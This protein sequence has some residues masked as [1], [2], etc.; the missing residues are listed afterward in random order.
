[1]F[2]FSK[3]IAKRIKKIFSSNISYYKKNDIFK[4]ILEELP[5][6]YFSLKW[7]QDNGKIEK[8]LFFSYEE[9][10]TKEEIC[11]KII[12][13]LFVDFLWDNLTVIEKIEKV[14][15]FIPEMGKKTA[16]IIVDNI[17]ND[18]FLHKNISRV[19]L[20][21]EI[22]NKNISKDINKKI[23]DLNGRIIQEYSPKIYPTYET[24]SHGSGDSTGCSPAPVAACFEETVE[25]SPG[26]PE[27]PEIKF[28]L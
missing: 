14:I 24:I 8:G 20:L 17:I 19:A 4:N 21:R 26:S 7:L 9:N 5:K 18:L 16:M 1:M 25:I 28:E 22:Y 13:K 3:S 10:E 15:F 6:E 23:K 27:K 12:Y 2:N 11:E